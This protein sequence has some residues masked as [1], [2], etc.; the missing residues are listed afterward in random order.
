MLPNFG[1]EGRGWVGS[2]DLVMLEHLG[3]PMSKWRNDDDDDDD[4]DD[5]DDNDNI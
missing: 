3:L 5:D 4:A 2:S 1:H